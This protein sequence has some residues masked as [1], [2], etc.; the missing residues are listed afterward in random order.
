[1][2][3]ERRKQKLHSTYHAHFS[4]AVRSNYSTVLVLLR[5]TVSVELW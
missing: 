2:Q 3:S 4:S 1:M 5:Y